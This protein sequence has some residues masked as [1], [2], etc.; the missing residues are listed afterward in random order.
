MAARFVTQ[1]STRLDAD[2]LAELERAAEEEVRQTRSGVV[3]DVLSN[4]AAARRAPDEPDG[5]VRS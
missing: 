4:W 3:R 2:L 5:E 1:V